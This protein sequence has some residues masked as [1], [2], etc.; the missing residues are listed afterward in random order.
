MDLVNIGFV[1]KPIKFYGRTMMT[2]EDLRLAALKFSQKY[3]HEDDVKVQGLLFP[4]K[5]EDVKTEEVL[6]L[7][8]HTVSWTRQV[9]RLCI[10][11]MQNVQ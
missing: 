11:S 10:D 5:A 7:N 4:S 3:N 6:N 9:T 2:S 1:T 8:H